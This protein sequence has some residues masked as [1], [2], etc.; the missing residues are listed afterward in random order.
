MLMSILDEIVRFVKVS[1]RSY[2][3]VSQ[4]FGGGGVDKCSEI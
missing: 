4:Y 3:W 2:V 1:S